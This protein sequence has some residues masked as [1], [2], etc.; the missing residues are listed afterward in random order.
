M[1][2]RGRWL[3]VLLLVLSFG[4]LLLS[5]A[6]RSLWIDEWFSVNIAREGSMSSA[7]ARITETERRPPAFYIML[8]VWAR[9]AG[10][11]DL[12]F[13]LPSILW[14]VLTVV[15]TGRL[16]RALRLPAGLSAAL[17]AVSPFF[18]LFAPMVRPYAMTATLAVASSWAFL[19]WRETGSGRSLAAYVGLSGLLLW[20]DYSGLGVLLAQNLLA[21]RLLERARWGLWMV[22]QGILVVLFVP[23]LGVAVAHATAGHQVEA[24]LARG[25]LGLVLKLAYPLLSFSS[26]ETIFPW[27]PRGALSLLVVNALAV[28]GLWRLRKTVAVPFSLIYGLVPLLFIVALFTFLIPQGTFVLIPSRSMAVYPVYIIL[29]A[30]GLRQL[31]PGWGVPTGLLMIVAWMGAFGNLLDGTHYHNPI[32]AVRTREMAAQVAMRAQPGDVVLSD[33]DSLFF[34]YYPST[35]RVANVFTDASDVL[36]RLAGAQ[37]VWLITLGRDRTRV[38]APAAR[39]MGWLAERGYREQERWGSGPEDPVYRRIK[40]LLLKR[41]DYDYKAVV[42]FFARR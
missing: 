23:W 3:L 5:A 15:L 33:E 21:I 16:A 31:P 30:A 39:I 29:V 26:G 35:A 41:P 27:D 36:D 2:W 10:A 6:G 18:L 8:F 12:A 20:T 40:E 42:Q 14:G 11:S 13:R 28:Y 17:L 22:V 32:Y 37:R 4:L 25:P 7:L 24:D 34:Y 9:L 38:G 1:T 19:S